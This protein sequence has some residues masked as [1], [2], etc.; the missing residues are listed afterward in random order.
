MT[1]TLNAEQI[2]TQN[3]QC[4]SLHK[5]LSN[6]LPILAMEKAKLGK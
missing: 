4:P 2:G 1:F 6:I 5:L 3:T